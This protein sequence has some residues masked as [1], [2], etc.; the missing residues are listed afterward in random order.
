[1]RS[2]AGPEVARGGPVSPW[3]LQGRLVGLGAATL[4]LQVVL[5]RELLVVALGYELVLLV[6]TGLVLLAS[7]MGA[8]AGL[9]AWMPLQRGGRLLLLLAGLAPVGALVARRSRLWL[10]ALPGAYLPPGDQLLVAAAVLLPVGLVSGW[11]LRLLA[12]DWLATGGDL[13]RAY[14]VESVGGVL[15]GILAWC[16]PMAGLS[17]WQMALIGSGLAAAAAWLGPP[18]GRGQRTAAVALWSAVLLL[19]FSGSKPLD[20]R[21]TAWTHADLV[22]AAD[23]PYGRVTVLRRAGQVSVLLND[24]LISSSEST[25]AEEF[26]QLA[27]L[28]HERPTRVLLIGG[29][30]EG[31]VSEVLA[32][33]ARSVV[34]VEMDSAWVAAAAPL[35]NGRVRCDLDDAR[36]RR[37]YDD[38]VRFLRVADPGAADLNPYLAPYDLV[39]VSMGEPQSGQT[40]RLYSTE[41]FGLCRQRL[42]AAGVLAFRL[43][44]GEN[45]RSPASLWRS[46]SVWAA[47][48]SVFGDVLVLPGDRDL[49]VASARPLSRDP[50]VLAARWQSRGGPGHLLSPQYLRYRLTDDRLPSLAQRLA[51]T[52]SPANTVAW[53]V[54]YGLSHLV[55]LS[56]F[57]VAWGSASWPV[58]SVGVPTASAVAAALLGGALLVWSHRCRRLH[59]WLWAAWAGASG[60]VLEGALLLGYQGRQG[61]LCRDLGLLFVLYM[62]G[63]AAGVAAIGRWSS[64][65]RGARGPAVGLSLGLAAVALV[66][67]WTLSPAGPWSAAPYAGLL[68]ASGCCCGALFGWAARPGGAGTEDASRPGWAGR[69]CGADL[70]GGCVGALAS[71]L[72]LL[73]L[74]GLPTTAL[75][76]AGGALVLLAWI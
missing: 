45:L 18:S 12:G 64:V 20:R 29:T 35:L 30:L 43:E 58:G 48:H 49:F 72:V 32:Q 52:P 2:P 37:V 44:G 13:A 16:L 6:G 56:R 51:Q 25:D 61:A 69:L 68:L 24:A 26:V 1:M 15:G 65:G 41:F 8:L 55:W 57:G 27:A 47:L 19:A 40:S 60:M 23:T 42:A 7:A 3:W 14:A 17:T 34:V 39:L 38:P 9:P 75:C 54:C 21:M 74:L 28:Q 62:A 70:L 10:D 36:V 73:P 66:T 67:A 63:L 53:P 31:L 4:L 76:V 5:L 50:E 46:A 22:D 11:A 33:R 71:S 59:R